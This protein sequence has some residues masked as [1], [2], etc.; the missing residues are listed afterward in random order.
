MGDKEEHDDVVTGL[1]LTDEVSLR[2]ELRDKVLRIEELEAELK[3]MRSLSLNPNP[4]R[5]HSKP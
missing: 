1:P 4:K 3:A 2:A 5:E